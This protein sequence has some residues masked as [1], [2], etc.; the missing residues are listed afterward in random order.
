[1]N[2]RFFTGWLPQGADEAWAPAT[3]ERGPLRRLI[4]EV[5]IRDSRGVEFPEKCFVDDAAAAQQWA[6]L[7]TA[8]RAVIVAGEQTARAVVQH[9][10]TAFFAREVRVTGMEF[11]NRGRGPAAREAAQGDS[12][13]AESAEGAEA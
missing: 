9:G 5:M 3:A 11:P 4:F 1:M 8:G 6:P 12:A 13:G 7:L 10:R 2:A